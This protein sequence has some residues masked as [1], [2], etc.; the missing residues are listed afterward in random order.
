L[1]ALPLPCL[2][3][4]T[5]PSPH[6]PQIVAEAVVGGVNIVQWRDR[7]PDGYPP[8]R[9]ESLA[10]LNASHPAL[11]LKNVG[12]VFRGI[13][14]VHGI[15]LPEGRLTVEAS[16]CVLSPGGLVGRSVHSV[17]TAREAAVQGADYLVA[18]TIFASPSHPDRPPAGLGFLR[19]VC[20][21]VSLPVLAIGGVTPQ[22][23]KLCL[24]VG[25]AGVAVLSPIMRATDPQAAA[26]TYRAAL[27]NNWKK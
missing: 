10:M 18:G 12:T 27:D 13:P 21:A 5:E 2:M 4:V 19:D 1:T 24:E 7:R 3:L 22:N 25:A 23:L 16:R 9:T 26:Q 6:L 17:D 8:T 14:G 20:A 11:L 15:H